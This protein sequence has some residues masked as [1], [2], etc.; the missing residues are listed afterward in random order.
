M[1]K[2]LNLWTVERR[3]LGDRCKNLKAFDTSEI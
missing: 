3:V 2:N 1:V